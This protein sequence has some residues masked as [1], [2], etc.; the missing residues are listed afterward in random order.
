M[1]F[2]DGPWANM[3]VR[4]CDKCWCSLTDNN[5]SQKHAY[6]GEEFEASKSSQVRVPN[7]VDAVGI[8]GKFYVG[9]WARKGPFGQGILWQSA[10][11][12]V[13]T[14]FTVRKVRCT[15][16]PKYSLWWKRGMMDPN[17]SWS[18]NVSTVG[19]CEKP[20]MEQFHIELHDY[21]RQDL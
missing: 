13:K 2:E 8:T 3:E 6:A 20:A 4:S 10:E 12:L 5:T 14:C 7:K 16:T 17:H 19:R 21:G 18:L 1:T 11:G 9:F 15:T